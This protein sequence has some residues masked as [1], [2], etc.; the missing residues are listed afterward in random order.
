MASRFDK[1]FFN[2]SVILVGPSEYVAKDCEL[3]DVDSYDI[4][5]RLN[6]HWR[7][8]GGNLGNRTDVICHCLNKNQISGA[9]IVRMKD[10]K[11]KLLLRNDFDFVTDKRKIKHFNTLNKDIGF[12]DMESIPNEFFCNLK[13]QVGTNPSTGVLCIMY[14]LSRSVKA[15]DVVG[16]DFYRT[17]YYTKKDERFRNMIAKGAVGHN[18]EKQLSFMKGVFKATPNLRAVGYLKTVLEQK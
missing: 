9:D 14:L 15:L 7:K 13:K 18:I 5:V 11:I 1:F 3:I 10:D 6:C 4:V 16:F 12:K 2:K 17:L 8:I